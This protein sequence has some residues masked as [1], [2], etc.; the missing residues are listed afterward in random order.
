MFGLST[1]AWIVVLVAVV[2]AIRW[3]RS[4]SYIQNPITG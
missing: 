4:D 3:A 1:K 2:V